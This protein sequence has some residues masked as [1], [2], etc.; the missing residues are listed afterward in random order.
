MDDIA[1]IPQKCFEC[2]DAVPSTDATPRCAGGCP[3]PFRSCDACGGN[4]KPHGSHQTINRSTS[5]TAARMARYGR[6]STIPTC[7]HCGAAKA[8]VGAVCGCPG[9]TAKREPTMTPSGKMGS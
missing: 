2:G 3:N 1:I 5:F 9:D 8:G 6:N 4:F 7:L